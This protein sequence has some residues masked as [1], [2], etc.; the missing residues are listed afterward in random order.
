MGMLR[1]STFRMLSLAFFHLKDHSFKLVVCRPIYKPK[2]SS[3]IVISSKQHPHALKAVVDS[4]IGRKLWGHIDCFSCAVRE[5]VYVPNVFID[6]TS[7]IN[8]NV[9]IDSLCKSL[10]LKVPIDHSHGRI[11][12]Y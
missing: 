6:S 1:I 8:E 12:C 10:L 2:E 4:K 11:I 3:V 9:F 7:L 5:L